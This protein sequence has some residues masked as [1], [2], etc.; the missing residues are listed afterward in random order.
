MITNSSTGTTKLN[1][2]MKQACEMTGCIL[3]LCDNLG[4][5]IL[6]IIVTNRTNLFS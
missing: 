5:K 3:E 2:Q 1:K 4:N 6:N